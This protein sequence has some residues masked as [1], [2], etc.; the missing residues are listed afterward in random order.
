MLIE[1]VLLSIHNACSIVSLLKACKKKSM[2]DQIRQLV[3]KFLKTTPTFEKNNSVVPDQ[4][5]GEAS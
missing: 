4:L 3:H 1:T 5:A 2:F